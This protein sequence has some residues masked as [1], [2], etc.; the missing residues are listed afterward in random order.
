MAKPIKAPQK[1]VE[2]EEDDFEDETEE[3]ST[4]DDSFE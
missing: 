3:G 2:V 4:E 1:P